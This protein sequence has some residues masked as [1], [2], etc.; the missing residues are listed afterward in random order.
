LLVYTQDKGGTRYLLPILGSM[1][2]EVSS[3]DTLYVNHTHSYDL[4]PDA[5]RD[6]SVIPVVS[7]AM[8]KQE[9]E[10]LLAQQE[11]DAVLCTLS[12]TKLD[13]S[14]ANLIVAARAQQIPTLGF[15]DHWKGYD[16]F[17]NP[18]GKPE[19]CPDWLGV[20]DDY[21]AQNVRQHEIP[22]KKIEVVGHPWLERMANNSRK[23]TAINREC[24]RIVV[25]SQPDSTDGSFK[26]IFC[27]KSNGQTLLEKIVRIVSEHYSQCSISYRPHPKEKTP[28]WLPEVV[29]IDD[30][31]TDELL[32]KYDVYMGLDSILLFEANLAGRPCIMLRL[33]EFEDVSDTAIPY[34][35]AKEVVDMDELVY[36]IKDVLSDTE[37]A[38]AFDASGSLHKCEMFL[39]DFLDSVRIC[40]A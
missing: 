30:S 6:M 29:E 28:C 24:I 31:S 10:R 13:L 5:I 37:T 7:S 38:P 17:L 26:S 14:N 2:K 34:M 3:F 1:E 22:V 27:R 15:L 40:D 18:V 12:S 8:S 36:Q 9:W 39:N 35:Y 16:R 23:P 25:I 20:I 21:C 32:A 19:Y 33:P 11:I 4:L